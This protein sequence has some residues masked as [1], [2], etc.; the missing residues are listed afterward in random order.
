[1]TETSFPAPVTPPPRI[2]HPPLNPEELRA[3]YP[4]YASVR[5]THTLHVGESS[6]ARQQ[7]SS[8][9]S[10]TPTRADLPNHGN[11]SL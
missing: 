3:A 4:Y 11:N 6:T 7:W 1:M 5:D 2:A 9:S 8:G 10:T